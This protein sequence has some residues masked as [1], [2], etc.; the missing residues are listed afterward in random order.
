MSTKCAF[1]QAFSRLIEEEGS[2]STGTYT[3]SNVDVVTDR[4]FVAI[5]EFSYPC[6]IISVSDSEHLRF[7]PINLQ[8]LEVQFHIPCSFKVAENKN[9]KSESKCSV[10]RLKTHDPDIRRVFFS[11]CA[12]IKA[13]LGEAPAD[14]DLSSA[15]RRL[16]E[17]FRSLLD[18]PSRSVTGLFGELVFI[19]NSAAPK[20]TIRAW[21]NDPMERYDFSSG[22]LKIEVKSSANRR[23]IHEFSYEQCAVVS[24]SLYL[25]ASLFTER[26]TGGSSIEELR[27]SIESRIANDPE[28]ILKLREVIAKTLGSSLSEAL[29]IK[30]DLSLAKESVAFFDVRQIPAI[31]SAVPSG[32]SNVRFQSDV[33]RS[34]E[35]SLD[36]ISHAHLLAAAYSGD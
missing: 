2:P 18:L 5:D 1:E 17:I 35:I 29:R 28:A 7:A 6:V 23:R 21:R 26:S 11:V 13:M 3:A 25:I 10:L 31:R 9:N 33:S 8:N 19:L 14:A 16:A 12:S 15:L 24:D 20:A 30:C 27:E 36:E 22:D 32:V 4:W 34:P